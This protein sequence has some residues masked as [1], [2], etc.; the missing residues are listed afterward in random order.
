MDIRKLYGHVMSSEASVSTFFFLIFFSFY[1]FMHVPATIQL[2]FSFVAFA[3]KLR[4]TEELQACKLHLN[5]L[6]VLAGEYENC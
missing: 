3:A 5:R 1:L 6:S 4:L 2:V